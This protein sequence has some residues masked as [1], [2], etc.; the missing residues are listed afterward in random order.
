MLNILN[1]YGWSPRARHHWAMAL[2]FIGLMLVPLV[3][4][5]SLIPCMW[6]GWLFGVCAQFLSPE[7][8]EN[9]R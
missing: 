1:L 6:G 8:P 4:W 9:E 3:G 5:F 7:V 2:T